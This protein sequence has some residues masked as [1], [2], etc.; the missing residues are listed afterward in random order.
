MKNILMLS[1][2][3]CS[4]LSTH[5]YEFSFYNNTDNPI[6]IAIQFTSNDG[7]E[8]LYSQLVKPKSMMTFTPGKI[9][10]PDI[11]WGFCLDNIYYVENPTSEQKMH[12]FAKA[13]WRKVAVT[14]VQEKSA[15]KKSYSAK[16]SKDRL[17]KQVI[18]K[19]NSTP[20]AEKSLCRDRH[21][22]IIH[23]AQNKVVIT[24]SLV[25]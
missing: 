16:A 4:T 9:D 25:E 21:F 13:P 10:I 12:H 23:D 2:I 3:V 20:L 14:W 1:I 8:P 19:E 18:T 11:K 24:S 17:T 22:D 15:T 7:N 6:G 5:A